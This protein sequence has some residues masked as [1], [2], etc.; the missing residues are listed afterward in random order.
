MVDL[1][2]GIFIGLLLYDWGRLRIDSA[3]FKK[4]LKTARKGATS[5]NK[6]K[7]RYED[8]KLKRS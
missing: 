3:I 2:I 7:L 5:L 4:G 1:I 6:Y 8:I